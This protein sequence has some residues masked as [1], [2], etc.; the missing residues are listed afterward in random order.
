MNTNN[1]ISNNDLID[2]AVKLQQVLT[3]KAV[4]SDQTFDP[5]VNPIT[6]KTHTA[7]TLQ[8]LTYFQQAKAL[9]S[10][11][12]NN[13]IQS[14]YLIQYPIQQQNIQNNLNINT[15]NQFYQNINKHNNDI[16]MIDQN[17]FNSSISLI[18]PK[19][20]D[21]VKEDAAQ[22]LEKSF[23]ETNSS[24]E[25][26]SSLIKPIDSITQSSIE[27]KTESENEENIQSNLEDL[28]E[29]KGKHINKS[30]ENIDD[31]LLDLDTN[32]ITNLDEIF[33]R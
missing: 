27:Q 15:S 29:I 10:I 13:I 6:S 24:I 32:G 33:L 9:N 17:E 18:S 8:N 16:K 30:A 25:I 4:T 12:N 31:V 14:Q 11:L 20:L 7:A 5:V 21:D 19:S 3:Y 2:L 26:N 23:L 1:Q 28:K 22:N